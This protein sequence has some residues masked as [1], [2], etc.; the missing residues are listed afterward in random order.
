MVY[1]APGQGE[2]YGD[3]SA[4]RRPADRGCICA[5]GVSLSARAQA[6]AALPSR[7]A[8]ASS[9]SRR[10]SPPVAAIHSCSK[11]AIWTSSRRDRHTCLTYSIRIPCAPR[12]SQSPGSHDTASLHTWA[13][14]SVSS[15]G[16]DGGIRR[17]T[18]TTGMSVSA[19]SAADLRPRFAIEI[20]LCPYEIWTFSKEEASGGRQPHF[21]ETFSH[22]PV[23]SHHHT[24]PD[25][26]RLH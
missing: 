20:I 2:G 21:V 18:S 3:T 1:S 11:C 22:P 16:G 19:S 25:R 17:E 8:I 12:F 24:S 15:L 5:C 10:S 6:I 13:W 23:T 9:L 7:S 4:S 14:A 26:H